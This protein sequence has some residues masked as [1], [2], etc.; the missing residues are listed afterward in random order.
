[1]NTHLAR[2]MLFRWYMHPAISFREFT[3]ITICYY[4]SFTNFHEMEIPFDCIYL[5]IANAF[6][7]VSHQRLQTN[8]H[9]RDQLNIIPC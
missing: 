9:F 5:D 1:M 7:R 4:K 2:E 6:D 3:I 8:T